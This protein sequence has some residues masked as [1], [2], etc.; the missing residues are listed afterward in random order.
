MTAFSYAVIVRFTGR[1][2]AQRQ[3]RQLFRTLKE[4]Y[5]VRSF[6][7]IEKLGDCVVELWV[8]SATVEYIDEVWV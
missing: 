4:K 8:R 1:G 7:G 2:E 3:L 6:L 5:E